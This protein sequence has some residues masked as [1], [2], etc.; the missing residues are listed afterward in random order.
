MDGAVRRL[1]EIKHT[2]RP[3]NVVEVGVYRGPHLYSAT[4]MIRIQ[5]DLRDLEAWPTNRLPGFTDQ[6]IGLL[7]AVGQH[8]CSFREPGGFLIRLRDGTWLGHVVEHVAIELQSLAGSQVTR[9]KTRSV[10]GREGVYNVLYAYEEEEIGL[11][12]GRLA[13]QLVDSLLPRSA[14]HPGARRVHGGGRAA[15]G[16][17]PLQSGRRDR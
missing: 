16:N 1:E 2:Q 3:M 10:K 14:W 13:L 9:G 12:A 6:L 5:L 15:G 11:L 8:G 7:P 17:R 4:P